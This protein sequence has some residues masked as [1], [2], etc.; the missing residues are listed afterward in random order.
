L[1][2]PCRPDVVS[3]RTF[4]AVSL[5][6]I[7]AHTELTAHGFRSTFREWTAEATGYPR[8]VAELALAHVNRDKVEAAYHA[9]T[10]S[11]SAAG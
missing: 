9:A 10:C 1:P 11:R 5:P 8:E 3:A 2:S 4:T 7:E 6:A